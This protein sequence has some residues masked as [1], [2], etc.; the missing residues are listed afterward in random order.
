MAFA[1]TLRGGMAFTRAR[2]DTAWLMSDGGILKSAPV[3]RVP[4]CQDTGIDLGIP[5]ASIIG[6]FVTFKLVFMRLSVKDRR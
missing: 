2:F 4:K 6:R 1:K 5:R 3:V